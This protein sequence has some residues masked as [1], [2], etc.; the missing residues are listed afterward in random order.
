[1]LARNMVTL[2]VPLT[3]IAL[4]IPLILQKVPRNGFY[5]FRTAFT[6]SSDEI[7]YRANK[8]SG[9]ALLAAGVFWLVLAYVLP[10]VMHDDR[11]A[12]R[13]VGWLGASSVIGGC[14]VSFWL[15]YKK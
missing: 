5:G 10:G 4:A 11:S 3:I 7:W 14:A 15:T 6:M 13:L 9:I 2:I 1:M 8:I 12:Y